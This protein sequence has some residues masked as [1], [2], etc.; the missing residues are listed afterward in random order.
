MALNG[1][2]VAITM[3][4]TL[5]LSFL[6]VKAY[7]YYKGHHNNTQRNT[8]APG[9]SMG[10]SASYKSPRTSSDRYAAIA[11][12]GISAAGTYLS[13]RYGI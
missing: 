7:T 11:D 13:K 4:G 2:V 5:I 6:A 12:L 10:I 8:Y 1:A 9:S 3:A